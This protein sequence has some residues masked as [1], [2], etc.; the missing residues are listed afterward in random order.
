MSDARSIGCKLRMR[1]RCAVRAGFWRGNSATKAHDQ[2]RSD[3]YEH[4][5]LEDHGSFRWLGHVGG[6]CGA[7]L[8][9]VFG[10]QRGREVAGVS[11][12]VAIKVAG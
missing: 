1:E 9:A 8:L 2:R 12:V 5:D 4:A 10:R 7:V 3:P 11:N 6:L